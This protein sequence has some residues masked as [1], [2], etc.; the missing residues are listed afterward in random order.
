MVA[1]AAAAL[2]ALAAKQQGYSC[3][4]SRAMWFELSLFE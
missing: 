4:S 1:A 2:A 3:S